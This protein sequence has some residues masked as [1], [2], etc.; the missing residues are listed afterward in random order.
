MPRPNPCRAVIF[1][2][3][4]VLTD[5]AHLHFLAWRALAESLGL[6]FDEAFNERLKG[7][8][9][10]GSLALILA[11]DPWRTWREADKLTLAARKNAHYQ[12]LLAGLGPNDLLPGAEEALLACRATGLRTALASVSHNAPTVHHRPLRPRR[13]RPH[14]P[15]Q[16]TGPGNLPDRRRSAW[17]ATSRVHRRRRCAGRHRRDQGGG[18]VCGRGGGRGRTA[19][20][21]RADPQPAGAELAGARCVDSP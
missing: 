13:R 4:G 18:D 16:Q 7:V 2:L 8:D 10:M 17:C 20:S 21:G 14:D 15:P 12:R 19:G 11:Q 1:D 9:R 5:T 3:D 6:P